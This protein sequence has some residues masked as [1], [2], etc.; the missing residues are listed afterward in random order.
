MAVTRELIVVY[1]AYTVGTTSGSVG[2]DGAVLLER[3]HE[4]GSVEF[5]LLVTGATAALFAANCVA[6]EAAFR[7]PF[8]DLTVEQSGE[9]LLSALQSGATA[10]DPM[11][12]IT[13]REHVADTGRSR[14]YTVRI[15]FGLPANTGAEPAV[16]L[17]SQSVNVAY[18]P[19]RRRTVTISGVFTA[20]PSSTARAQYLS[21]VDSHC[22]SIL[23]ALGVSS[24]ARE[25]VEEPDTRHDTNNRLL[26]F[27]RVYEELVFSQ[28][29]AAL[30]DPELV[31][32]RLT[33]STRREAPGDTP[34]TERLVTASL[35]YD[36]WVDA[37]ATTAIVAKYNSIRSWLVEQMQAVFDGGSFAVTEE[38]ADF[39]RDENRISVRMS[40]LGTAGG[41]PI[42]EQRVT[43]DDDDQTGVEVV[44]AWSGDNLA[45]YHY[46]GPRIVVRT[47]T[48]QLKRLGLFTEQDMLSFMAGEVSTARGRDPSDARGGTW[49]VIRRRA[50][51]TPLRTGVPPETIDMTEMQGS[52]QLRY[53]KDPA[54]VSGGG[55]GG[56]SITPRG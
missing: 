36:V 54:S 27:T 10:L 22:A 12:T 29:G 39:H 15:E 3:S 17:R 46:P 8:Q 16:G 11:P 18:D 38:D 42:L 37:T 40:G 5:S 19:A 43:V 20:V 41:N 21:I 6:T 44:P 4:R 56:D 1:G 28:G 55:G 2:P 9:S 49:L 7:L 13:K 26:E 32:Q 30:D 34:T 45:A 47:V 23:T 33:V 31:R 14:R 50:A 25:L 24:S 51:A 52:T 53:A 35:S 48:H